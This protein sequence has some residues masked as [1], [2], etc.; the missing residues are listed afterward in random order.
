MALPNQTAV[1]AALSR[2]TVRFVPTAVAAALSRHA[3]RFAPTERGGYSAA[4]QL[5]SF[6]KP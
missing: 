6:S 2:R 1:A 3:G 5:L 4:R